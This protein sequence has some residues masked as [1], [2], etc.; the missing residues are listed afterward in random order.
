[1]EFVG[2]VGG[3]RGGQG[4]EE[5]NRNDE[6]T[7]QKTIETGRGDA[8]LDFKLFFQRA[9]THLNIPEPLIPITHQLQRMSP[10]DPQNETSS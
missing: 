9:R 5:C 7:P 6:Q 4:T 1:M 3:D 10:D 2:V 8:E